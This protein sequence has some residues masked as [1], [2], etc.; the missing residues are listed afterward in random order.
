[1]SIWDDEQVVSLSRNF[2]KRR[3]VSKFGISPPKHKGENGRLYIPRHVGAT[4]DMFVRY[5]EVPEGIAFRI[6]Q[7]GDY[8]VCLQNASSFI[9]YAQAPY[10]LCKWAGEKAISIEVEPFNG[11]YLVRPDQFK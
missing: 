10:A 6:A 5:I 8:K 9:L 4:T 3:D 1:M 2:R 7:K 11:G